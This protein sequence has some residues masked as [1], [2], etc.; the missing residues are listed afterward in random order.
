MAEELEKQVETGTPIPGEKYVPKDKWEEKAIAS[1]KWKPKE[2]WEGDPEDWRSARE[3]VERGELFDKIDSQNKELKQMRKVLD[4]LKDHHLRVKQEA[5]EDAIA[6]LRKQRDTAKKEEDLGKVLEI[7]EEIDALQIKQRQAIEKTKNELAA[8]DAPVNEPSKAFKDWHR[9]NTWYNIDG[10]DAMS[11]YANAIG[12]AYVSKNRGA[13]KEEDLLEY[14]AEKVRKEFPDK[15]K[16]KHDPKVE[17]GG[18]TRPAKT[19]SDKYNLS[20]AEKRV[21]ETLVKSGVMTWEAYV[22]DLKEYDKRKV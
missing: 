4:T 8:V 19:V 10:D 2:E 12:D 9:D 18:S 13:Y 11:V 20:D 15:F 21:G 6:L 14:V 3:Y 16:Q 7:T 5:M 1:G 22:K 17:G